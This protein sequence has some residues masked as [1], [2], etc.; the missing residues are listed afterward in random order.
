MKSFMKPFFALMALIFTSNFAFAQ[1]EAAVTDEE[2]RKYAVAMDSVERMKQNI[3]DWM[4]AEVENNENMTGTR[5]NDLSKIIDDSVKLAEANA[6]QQE[7]DFILMV[8]TKKDK[9]TED[10]NTT[11]KSLAIDYLGEG[12]RN[13]K[14]IKD[15]ISNDPAVKEKYQ[16]IYDEVA[17]EG[18]DEETAEA[19]DQ[20]DTTSVDN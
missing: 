15:A 12:G 16:I 14:R 9:M 8:K 6:T 2:L 1:D 5:F 4:T 11:F 18:R 10:I 3:I 13:Y 7:I 20:K 19:D 17:A